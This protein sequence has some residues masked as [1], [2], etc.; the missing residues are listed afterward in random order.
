MPPYEWPA[1]NDLCGLQTPPPISDPPT[2]QDLS[3]VY[4]LKHDFFLATSR[5]PNDTLGKLVLLEHKM[6]RSRLEEQAA[7]AEPAGIDLALANIQA[8]LNQIQATQNAMQQTLI[9]LQQDQNAMQQTP[10]QLQQD[11]N[12]MQQTPIQLQQDQN[13]MQQTQNAML[14]TLIQLQQDQNSMLQDQAAIRQSLQS[15]T[16]EIRQ[17]YAATA[18]VLDSIQP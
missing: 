2:L 17:N 8:T 12:A 11:Q 13:A 7:P 10:I 9:Q 1:A 5:N 16:T 14:Q 15:L 18:K 6:C 3:N 4:V